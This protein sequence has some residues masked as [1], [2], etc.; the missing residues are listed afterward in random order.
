MTTQVCAY[1]RVEYPAPVECTHTDTQCADNVLMRA[2]IADEIE[3]FRRSMP[4]EV[5]AYHGAPRSLDDMSWVLA[6]ARDRVKD[7]D[8]SGPSW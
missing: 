8:W 7:G 6:Q 1:C 2:Q 4:D 5:T 3:A